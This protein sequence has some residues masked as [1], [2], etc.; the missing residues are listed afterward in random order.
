MPVNPPG[1]RGA[2][3]TFEWHNLLETVEALR[4]LPLAMTNSVSAGLATLATIGMARI[5]EETPYG[6]TGKLR[7]ST[8]V[9]SRGKH[10][11][12]VGQ[13]AQTPP[14][15]NRRF[16]YGR[17]VRLGSF[18][19]TNNSGFIGPRNA[20]ALYWKPKKNSFGLD[21]PISHVGV[22]RATGVRATRDHPGI[23]RPNDYV[24]RAVKRMNNDIQIIGRTIG[25]KATTEAFSAT[26]TG[27][28]K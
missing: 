10:K 11:Y 4:K 12:I 24:G 25:M 23:S 5:R 28:V 27:K 2:Q 9:Q 8:I 1:M 19:P 26:R 6:D 21:H 15:R 3:I 13:T 14:D 18:K 20:K 17:A 16:F 7:N 22:N